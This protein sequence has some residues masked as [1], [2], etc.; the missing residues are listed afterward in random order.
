MSYF[1]EIR[2]KPPKIFLRK[3]GISLKKFKKLRKAVTAHLNTLKEESPSKPQGRKSEICLEDR[4]LLTLFYLRHYSIFLMLGEQFGVS[5]SYA[6]KI[7]HRFASILVQI[8]RLPNR[9]ALTSESLQ[10][11]VID[12]T[13][14]AIERPKR[15]QKQYYSGKKKRHTI[16]AQLIIDLDSL[17]IFSVFCAKGKVHDFKM[18]KQSCPKFHP[19]SI[20]LAD[21]GYQGMQKIYA[22]TQIPIKKKKGKTLTP[23]EK[24]YNRE[25]AQKRIVIEHVNRR[26]KI[27]R[28][29]K[30]TYRGKHKN[31]GKIW[32]IIAGLVNLRYAI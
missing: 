25:L 1:N 21:S 24:Q 32:N 27:F 30:E 2:S 14:Q 15:K 4:L 3:V 10:Q 11:V 6:C 20:K 22:H 31:Y 16:K 17:T 8:L 7:F 5:E 26:C 23:E 19:E 18:L 29:V 9:H 28:I 13:E 12:V